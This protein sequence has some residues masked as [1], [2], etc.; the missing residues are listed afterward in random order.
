MSNL[1]NHVS[2]KTVAISD[3][4][5]DLTTINKYTKADLAKLTEINNNGAWLNTLPVVDAENAVKINAVEVVLAA[6]RGQDTMLVAV[7]IN[8]QSE[9]N[10]Y[11]CGDWRYNGKLTGDTVCINTN[12]D[13]G[14]NR[15]VI[16]GVENDGV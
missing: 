14:K 6:M 4:K 16:R 13:D 12:V 9:D 7:N 11:P 2:L 8:P 1:V 10:I 5:I 3:L 15:I